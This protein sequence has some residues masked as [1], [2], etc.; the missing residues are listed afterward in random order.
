MAMTMMKIDPGS[1][2]RQFMTTAQA[3]ALTRRIVSLRAKRAYSRSILPSSSLR[4][5]GV[6]L[7]SQLIPKIDNM[8]IGQFFTTD[9]WSDEFAAI[10]GSKLNVERAEDLQEAASRMLVGISGVIS[11]KLK[12]PDQAA[13]SIC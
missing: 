5:D 9:L 8:T 7:L 2:P 11:G 3:A 10:T 6:M 12:V 4:I 13:R 1:T